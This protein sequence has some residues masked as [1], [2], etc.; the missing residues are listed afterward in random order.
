MGRDDKAI[1]PYHPE[2]QDDMGMTF[3]GDTRLLFFL[4]TR[5]NRDT[6]TEQG[7]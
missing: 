6:G 2:E 5:H 7:L 3:G 4:Q 1:D